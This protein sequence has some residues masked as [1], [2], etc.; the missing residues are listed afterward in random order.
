MGK[1]K[2]NFRDEIKSK[3]N[4][5]ATKISF[6]VRWYVDTPKKDRTEEN[7]DEKC[8]PIANIDFHAAMMN[9]L[10]REDVQEAIRTYMKQKKFLRITDIYESMCE[11]AQ[12]GD[13]NAARFVLDFSKSDFFEDE[14]DEMDNYL[15][16]INI[17]A[18]KKKGDSNGTK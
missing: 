17:P 2:N 10:V 16:G 14:A 12:K 13:V 6:F 5:N 4:A 18:L 8:K 11:K 7:Y 9:W 3:I 1:Q 15:S